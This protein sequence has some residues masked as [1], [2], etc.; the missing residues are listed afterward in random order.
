MSEDYFQRLFPAVCAGLGL[1]LA[2]A[3][4][5]LLMRR[6]FWVRV[7][8]TLVAAGV[9]LGAAAALEQPG[10]TAGAAR[11]MAFGLVLCV[12]LASRRVIGGL[13]AVV[14]AMNRPAV[15]Y[16]LLTVA[17]VGTAIGAIFVCER[18]DNAAIDAVMADIELLEGRNP[19][20]T[21]ERVKATTDRGTRINVQEPIA[22]REPDELNRAEEKSLRNAH[23]DEQVIRRGP[24]DDHSN[25]HGWVFTGGRFLL[26]GDFVNLILKE[27]GYQEVYESHPGDLVVYRH[28]AQVLHTA[29]VRYVAEG[30]PVLVESKWGNLGVFLHPADKCPYG[31]EYTFYRSPRPGHLLAGIGGPAP[32]GEARPPVT[33]E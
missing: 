3:A 5:L 12:V 25:C 1:F 14:T 19:A 18:A 22:S 20:V 28:E 26:G 17:G 6:G 10:A 9:G 4:N 15:R 29:V 7:V 24:A 23:L 21:T 2:G 8:A 11:L 13:A 30:Q 32:S 27:N 16:G 31:T 33:T